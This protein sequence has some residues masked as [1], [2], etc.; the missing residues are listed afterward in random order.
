MNM[1]MTKNGFEILIICSVW[2]K[3]FKKDKLANVA[4]LIFFFNVVYGLCNWK[5]KMRLTQHRIEKPDV[6]RSVH[7]FIRQNNSMQ[8]VTRSVKMSYEMKSMNL[9]KWQLNVTWRLIKPH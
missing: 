3:K 9:H 5:K 6:Q 7:C 2:Q 8:P 4:A 1:N